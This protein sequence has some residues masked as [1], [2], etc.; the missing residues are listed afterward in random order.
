MITSFQ[1]EKVK[2]YKRLMNSK[3]ERDKDKLF[4]VEGRHLV[5]EAI[6]A[7][8]VLE[9]MVS[10]K[11]YIENKNFKYIEVTEGIMKKICDTKSPQGII[12]LC[13]QNTFDSFKSNQR[14]LL[15]DDIQDPGNLGTILRSCDAFNFDGI[16][17]NERTVDVYN[18][19]VVRA[20]QGA[21]FRV[22]MMKKDLIDYIPILREK[23][24]KVYGTSLDGESLSHIG[25]CE[26]MAFILGNEGNGVSNTLLQMTDKNIY[27][28]MNGESESLNVSIAASIIM[29]IFRK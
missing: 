26:N 25:S 5:E 18:P 14:L 28:E 12:A 16:V 15:I 29:Y 19:K 1:N 7:N 17:M 10:D 23:G 8:V 6:R 22:P 13:K 9:I 3:K 4:I 27:I 24:I 21:I 20:T 2:Y 11:K